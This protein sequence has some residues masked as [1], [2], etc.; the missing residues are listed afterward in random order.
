VTGATGAAIM[1]SVLSI[2]MNDEAVRLLGV[3]D[4]MVGIGPPGGLTV[5][6]RERLAS[7]IVRRAQVLTWANSLGNADG[8]P[9]FF[10]DLTGWECAD[11]SFH[12]EDEVPVAVTL[13]EESE[14]RISED[15]QRVLLSH[16]IAFAMGFARLVYALDPP[17]PVRCIIAANQTNATFRFH[18]IRPGERWNLPDLDQF[19]LDKVIEIDTQPVT[20]PL[21][22]EPN[23]DS[24]SPQVT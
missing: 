9:S 2:R 7:G 17:G 18:Q 23:A 19:R 14:P 11:S 3:L 12:L 10:P 5:G 13:T 8:A 4:G 22:R 6:L 16:G 15:D 24:A 1:G 21:A 20:H